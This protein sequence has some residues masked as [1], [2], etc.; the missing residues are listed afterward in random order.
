LSQQ[1]PKIKKS[2][3]HIRF[4]WFKITY[5]KEETSEIKYKIEKIRISIAC[6]WFQLAGCKFIL[7]FFLKFYSKAKSCWF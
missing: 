6:D 5:K 7:N 3:S 4:Y 1:R 2:K